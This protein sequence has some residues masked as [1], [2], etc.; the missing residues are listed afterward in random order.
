M[1]KK[2]WHCSVRCKWKASAFGALSL[3]TALIFTFLRTYFQCYR[4]LTQLL[5]SVQCT[6]L[7]LLCCAGS[8]LWARAVH[9][10][11]HCV[12]QRC[13]TSCVLVRT[14]FYFT[15]A[16][17]VRSLSISNRWMNDGLAVARL[18]IAG[19]FANHK[20][21]A[22]IDSSDRMYNHRLFGIIVS[23]IKCALLLYNFFQ[24]RV[25]H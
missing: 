3:D 24:N 2:L 14:N 23:P 25:R 18:V 17:S 5:E 7:G 20:K 13:H 21:Y 4:V 22:N 9:E 6:G 16:Y 19:A 10:S 1:T 12:N 8:L 15:L 11:Q